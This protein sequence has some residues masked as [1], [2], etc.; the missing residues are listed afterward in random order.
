MGGEN[1]TTDVL[2]FPV[3]TNLPDQINLNTEKETNNQVPKPTKNLTKWN[4]AIKRR[5]N[6]TKDYAE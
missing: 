3:V 1:P 5:I 4:T 6:T 2:E